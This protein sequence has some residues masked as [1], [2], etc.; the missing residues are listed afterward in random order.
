THE[1]RP[2]VLPEGKD[3]MASLHPDQMKK[4]YKRMVEDEFSRSQYRKFFDILLENNEGSVLWHC[5][6]GK[7][8]T[9]L[10]T[11]FLLSALG[12]PR[13]SIISD[14]LMT[15][16]YCADRVDRIV[17]EVLSRMEGEMDPATCRAFFCAMPEYIDEALRL[18]DE[19]FGSME[20]F[21]STEIGLSQPRLDKLRRMYLE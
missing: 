2:S 6:M 19:K 3:G 20:E 17:A 18:I 1:R 12:V 4:A 5:T 10:A 14:Y 15:N 13:E 16:Q 21:L 7:D 9:G 11:V 8:R